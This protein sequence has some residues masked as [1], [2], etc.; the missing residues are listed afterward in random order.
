M[1]AQLID[2]LK[3]RKVLI[4]VEGKDLKSLLIHLIGGGSKGESNKP[5]FEHV[6]V[7]DFTDVAA[8]RDGVNVKLECLDRWLTQI[9]KLL[10]DVAAGIKCIGIIRDAE[11]DLQGTLES[12]RH[13]F[14]KHELGLP[15]AESSW[16]GESK[17]TGY[18]MLRDSNTSKGCLEHVMMEALGDA[19][20]QVRGCAESFVD[21]AEPLYLQRNPN[22]QP[23]NWRAKAL[24]RAILAA[25]DKPGVQFGVSAKI[26]GL[27]DLEKPALKQMLE[28]IRQANIA[29]C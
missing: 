11:F 5:G 28:F 19:W 20:T 24:T 13:V 27:W 10:P 9:G 12:T 29:A 14:A 17:L 21:C 4:A 22:A 16:E 25:S 3:R 2:L 1:N 6:V 26:P 23:M 7:D 15:A 18:H 8:G